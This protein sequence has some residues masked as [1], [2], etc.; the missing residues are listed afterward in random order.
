MGI[1]GMIDLLGLI[2][3]PVICMVSALLGAYI[4]RR[5]EQRESVFKVRSDSKDQ[6]E[7]DVEWDNI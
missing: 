4:Y 1:S 7:R 2:V 3:L 5:G 6:H